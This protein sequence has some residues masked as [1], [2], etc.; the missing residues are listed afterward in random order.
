[1]SF[2]SL[3]FVSRPT[4]SSCK[5]N[6]TGKV[7]ET[8][9]PSYPNSIEEGGDHDFAG[10]TNVGLASMEDEPPKY[11]TETGAD[12]SLS[13]PLSP[14][15]NYSK[16]LLP[17]GTLSS[18][19]TT[20][21]TTDPELLHDPEALCAFLRQQIALPPKPIV[22]IRG[23]HSDKVYSWG[24]KRTDFDLTL[25]L[26]PLLLPTTSRSSHLNVTPVK[27]DGGDVD[28]LLSWAQRFCADGDERKRYG[29][30]LVS[31]KHNTGPLCFVSLLIPGPLLHHPMQQ[32]S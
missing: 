18:D 19:R 5:M 25:D 2:G 3:Y 30:V 15:I 31:T 12:P 20:R 4:A 7:A 27:G 23:T 24:A 32:T 1:M 21:T 28:P 13:G 10:H 9:I 11:T 6:H 29:R 26:T 14:S 8:D 17:N 22:R 16:H